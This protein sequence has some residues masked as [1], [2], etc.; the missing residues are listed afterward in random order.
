[1]G[2]RVMLPWP[3]GFKAGSAARLKELAKERALLRAY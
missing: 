2:V 1:M 3:I